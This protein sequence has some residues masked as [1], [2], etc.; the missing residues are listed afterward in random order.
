MGRLELGEHP[1]KEPAPLLRKCRALGEVGDAL[2]EHALPPSDVHQGGVL[3]LLDELRAQQQEPP[4][5]QPCDD[6]QGHDVAPAEAPDLSANSKEWRHPS[7]SNEPGAENLRAR[8]GQTFMGEVENETK[9]T[10][11]ALRARVSRHHPGP[12]C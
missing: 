1:R 12:E 11:W 5:A 7:G 9:A 6:R 4:G 2:T 10:R 3:L 8:A